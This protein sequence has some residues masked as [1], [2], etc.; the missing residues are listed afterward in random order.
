M[1]LHTVN[2]ALTATEVTHHHF[3]DYCQNPPAAGKDYEE[4]MWEDV[5]FLVAEFNR[6]LGSSWHDVRQPRTY[7]QFSCRGMSRATTAA[8]KMEHTFDGLPAWLEYLKST[9]VIF[10]EPDL[11]KVIDDHGHYVDL[12][13]DLQ[14]YDLS[15]AG[16]EDVLVSD[17][18]VDRW[19]KMHP[20]RGGESVEE[21]RSQVEE[22]VSR[23]TRHQVLWEKEQAR[24][25]REEEEEELRQQQAAIKAVARAEQEYEVEAIVNKRS[26]GW[27]VEYKVRW[28]GYTSDDDTWESAANLVGSRRA[29]AIYEKQHKN[30]K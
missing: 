1:R 24:L 7:N 6:H 3:N 4:T 23:R 14:V 13:E 2:K 21:Q 11:E 9:N 5:E 20:P 28:K 17:V 18:S 12:E 16:G 15:G 30:K 25:A 26:I 22:L 27:K 29:V 8:T 10:D 19:C